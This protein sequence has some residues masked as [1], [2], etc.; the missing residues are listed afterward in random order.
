M[1]PL[2]SPRVEAAL[3]GLA[4]ERDPLR[5]ASR[6]RAEL[7]DE[8]G[9]RAAELRALR[10]R[11]RGKLQGAERLL[12]TPKG[13]EQ[14]SAWQVAEARA[15]RIHGTDPEALVLDATA[16][17]GGDSMALAKLGQPLVAGEANLEIAR[18]LRHNLEVAG[19][20]A[21]RVLQ[22]SAEHPAV[23]ADVLLFDP[24]RRAKGP[25]H[26]RN[27][28]ARAREAESWSPS[29]SRTL[30]LARGARGAC[31]KLPPT[32]SAEDLVGLESLDTFHLEWV[33]LGGDSK[34]LSLWTGAPAADFAGSRSALVLGR[35]GEAH[36][37]EGEPER[38]WKQPTAPEEPAFLAEADPAVSRA[39]LVEELAK[40]C[41]MIPL[42]PGFP[43]L[44]GDEA[45]GPSPFLRSWRVLG[46]APLDRKRVRELCR[47]HD[48][49]RC[50]VKSRGV[51][52]SAEA[53]ADR[54]KGPGS[55]PGLMLVL[56][57]PEGRRV[58][59]VE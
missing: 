24:D 4:G 55:K 1:D 50:V 29:W 34:E 54:L 12:L 16:G 17:I 59:L 30:E 26:G 10:E 13:L 19:Q 3:A 6:L 14:A 42:G 38:G 21:P 48:V 41:G 7:G 52:E 40:G 31:I 15:R 25:S 36:R 39:G 27:P 11:A 49:G 46:S 9:R 47:S 33:S 23:T 58:F 5:V 37:L 35:A 57:L 56:G 43:Y 20:Q 18:M 2:S 45:P 44:G 32:W 53:L 22:A 51:G 8:L 28:R